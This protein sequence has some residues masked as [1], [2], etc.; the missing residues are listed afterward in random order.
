MEAIGAHRAHLAGGEGLEKREA[1]RAK[2]ELLG[3]LRERLV[4]EAISR[5]ESERGQL[6]G[7]AEQIAKR[8]ANPYDLVDEV[9]AR[10]S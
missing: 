4:F 8:E 7:L 2:A 3:L 1:A 5:L 9:V 6:E 10:L